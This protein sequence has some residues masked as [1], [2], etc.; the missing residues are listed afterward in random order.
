M[1]SSLKY[2]VLLD[3]VARAIKDSVAAVQVV[4]RT[5]SPGAR[6]IE[7]MVP[8]N[9]SV[10]PHLV[11]GSFGVEA[12]TREVEGAYG[13]L[14]T[15]LVAVLA[16]FRSY[17][18]SGNK[19]IELVE[20]QNQAVADA[21]AFGRSC[22][23]TVS[24]AISSAMH[25]E[26]MLFFQA[27][28]FVDLVFADVQ[29]TRKTYNPPHNCFTPL[30]ICLSSLTRDK[31]VYEF[32]YWDGADCVTFPL[33]LLYSTS[34]DLQTLNKLAAMSFV[35]RTVQLIHDDDE[36]TTFALVLAHG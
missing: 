28:L 21:A 7:L 23:E 12:L 24:A 22:L 4:C 14:C 26:A 13:E 6:L 9:S 27:N 3:S 35:G 30:G 33:H 29:A 32:A 11:A 18:E 34:A 5:E 19:R 16:R 8:Y 15:H 20:L 2:S 25:A 31:A 17:R 1:N 10:K 36:G